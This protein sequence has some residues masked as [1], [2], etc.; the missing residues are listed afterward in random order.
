MLV[1]AR[2]LND[3]VKIDGPCRVVIT[4]IRGDRVWLGFE[5]EPS[6]R[7]MREE[8]LTRERREGADDP[9]H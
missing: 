1:L 2:E 3:A 5:A 7:I 4:K 6:V 8:L 9:S